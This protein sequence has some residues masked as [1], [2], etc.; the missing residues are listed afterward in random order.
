MAGFSETPQEGTPEIPPDLH[1]RVPAALIPTWH[2]K[3]GCL[4][5]IDFVRPERR[6]SY[7]PE[8]WLEPDEMAGYKRYRQKATRTECAQE[9][10]LDQQLKADFLASPRGIAY[11]DERWDRQSGQTYPER[12]ATLQKLYDFVES[13]LPAQPDFQQWLRTKHTTAFILESVQK[14]TCLY[15]N[16]F[17][18]SIVKNK[19]ATMAV[20]KGVSEA[21][22]NH[23]EAACLAV[24][25]GLIEHR[26]GAMKPKDLTRGFGVG[27]ITT[28]VEQVSPLESV[29][30]TSGAPKPHLAK[31]IADLAMESDGGGSEQDYIAALDLILSVYHRRLKRQQQ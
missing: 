22:K 30:Q 23:D 11:M 28:T 19:Y 14:N 15:W 1:E 16:R 3:G 17:I 10:R 2:A 6:D 8:S 26:T 31:A 27:V 12:L 21:F 20:L 24:A 18:Y 9:D 29:V 13:V 4:Q 25:E 7:I 5:M